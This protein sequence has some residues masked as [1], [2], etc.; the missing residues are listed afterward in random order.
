MI[1]TT[2]NFNAMQNNNYETTIKNLE[3]A[4]ELLDERYYKKQISD[5]EYIRKSKEINSQI[6]HYRKMIN[7]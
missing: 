7:N 3:K 2:N 4:K 1:F 6:E 5:S